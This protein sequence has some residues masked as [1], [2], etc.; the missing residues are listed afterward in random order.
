MWALGSFKIIFPNYN[1]PDYG[2][3]A[4]PLVFYLVISSEHPNFQY[5]YFLRMHGTVLLEG[6]VATLV[7]HYSYSTPTCTQLES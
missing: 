3:V 2:K 7:A 6:N 4:Y 1:L 5:F